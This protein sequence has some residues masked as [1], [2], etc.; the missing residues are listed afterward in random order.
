M[1]NKIEEKEIKK[2]QARRGKGKSATLINGSLY[3]RTEN[4]I[5]HIDGIKRVKGAGGARK[6]EEV[7]AALR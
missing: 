1:N 3:K 5:G 6:R 2:E 7:R 4:G